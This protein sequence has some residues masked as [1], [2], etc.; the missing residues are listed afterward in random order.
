MSANFTPELLEKFAHQLKTQRVPL[1]RQTISDN[2]VTGLRAAIH[3]S[4]LIAFHV[5]Y[6][7]G[8]KRPF[9]RI[10][11]FDDPKDPDYISIDDARHVASVVLAL[12][13]KGIDVQD[14][15]HRRLVR[16]LQRDGSNWRPPLIELPAKRTLRPRT[17]K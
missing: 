17:P 3:K 10:G 11:T 2:V 4:G 14:G 1:E 8:E 13:R 16:E 7:V 5:S 6:W 9:M 12:G 15:L